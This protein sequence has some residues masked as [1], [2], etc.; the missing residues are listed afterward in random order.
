MLDVTMEASRRW[1]SIW[2]R[3]WTY[4]VVNTFQ[5]KLLSHV[6]IGID[7][8]Q[9][10]VTATTLLCSRDVPVPDNKSLGCCCCK[11]LPTMINPLIIALDD[12]MFNL[13]QDIPFLIPPV[14][15][16]HSLN[17]LHT[18]WISQYINQSTNKSFTIIQSLIQ[19]L[20]KSMG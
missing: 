18:E 4:F 20:N 3:F 13:V 19:S 8:C 5:T 2:W 15:F 10:G 7:H 17:H 16:P 6:I 11:S 1:R 9:L 14:F 12:D